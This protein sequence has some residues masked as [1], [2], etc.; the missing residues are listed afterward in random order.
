L[1]SQSGQVIASM[2]MGKFLSGKEG[3]ASPFDSVSHA[4]ICLQPRQKT[5]YASSGQSYA[6]IGCSVIQVD[7]I[8]IRADG[9]AAWEHNVVHVSDA[10]VWGVGTKNP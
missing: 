6:R 1:G 7:G 9:L 3:R 5:I 4:G 10:L 2:L 8:P